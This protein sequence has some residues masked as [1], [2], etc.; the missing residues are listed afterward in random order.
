MPHV[1]CGLP[2]LKGGCLNPCPFPFLTGCVD[3]I[4]SLLLFVAS[5]GAIAPFNLQDEGSDEEGSSSGGEIEGDETPPQRYMPGFIPGTVSRGRAREREAGRGVQDSNR[6]SEA[7]FQRQLASLLTT[8]Q[9]SREI[10]LEDAQ[11]RD[12]VLEL[13]TGPPSTFSNT[14]Y[15]IQAQHA[16]SGLSS[17]MDTARGPPGS[18]TSP[19]STL[20]ASFSHAEP[21]P[22]GSTGSLS[23]TSSSSSRQS[24]RTFNIFRSRSRHHSHTPDSLADDSASPRSPARGQSRGSSWTSWRWPRWT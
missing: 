10:M 14:R 24:R 13:L 7:S 21:S 15:S 8:I 16:P 9:Q 22:S 17:S 5:Q 4:E 18:P 12:P 23:S 20:S 11:E 3:C 19:V 2:H 1:P 6:P